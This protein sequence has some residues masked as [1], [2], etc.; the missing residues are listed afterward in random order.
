MHGSHDAMTVSFSFSQMD[1][2]RLLEI[3]SRCNTL[4]HPS[5]CP[6]TRD[7]FIKI[8]LSDTKRCMLRMQLPT[9]PSG[10]LCVDASTRA[11]FHM[12][13]RALF[14][15]SP[16]KLLACKPAPAC[17]SSTAKKIPS[18]N[19]STLNR[20]WLHAPLHMSIVDAVNLQVH[21]TRHQ[22]GASA[23]CAPRPCMFASLSS[24]CCFHFR[25][26]P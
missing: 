10:R 25:R 13:L 24:Q 23:C 12:Q 6:A 21:E 26:I 16:S 5:S 18:P 14:R 9:T 7:W 3:I 8:T 11:L 15:S 20:A 1:L 4:P 19:S 22:H 2:Y 17:T